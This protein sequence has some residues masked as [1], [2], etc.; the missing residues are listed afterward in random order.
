MLELERTAVQ[1]AVLP[2]ER[3]DHAA[4]NVRRQHQGAPGRDEP[5]VHARAWSERPIRLHE[6]SAGAD[7]DDRDVAAGAQRG[8]GG[9]AHMAA[10]LPPPLLV[11][12]DTHVP[13][14]VMY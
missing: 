12:R 10:A 1:D 2:V 13:S 14:A 5:D 3:P 4:Q 7:V 6:R 8:P 11:H 9:A